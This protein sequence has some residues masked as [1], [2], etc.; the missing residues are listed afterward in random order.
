MREI[1][2]FFGELI[3]KVRLERRLTQ[4]EVAER[5][6]CHPQYYKNLENGKGMPSIQVF[7]KIIRA[8]NMS[9]D[10]YVYPN[11]NLD[12]PIYQNI[13]R[14][15]G[16]LGDYELSVLSATAEALS[17]PKTPEIHNKEQE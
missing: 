1:D 15:M 11:H 6:N 16:N 9:A 5:I 4:E 10:A 7:C 13:I 2:P 17:Q 12:N 8:L 14:L 3:K